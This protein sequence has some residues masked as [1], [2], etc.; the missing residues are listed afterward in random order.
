[1]SNWW[2]EGISPALLGINPLSNI[3]TMLLSNIW[4]E[5]LANDTTQVDMSTFR[6]FTDA[7]NG[8]AVQLGS[9]SP[10]NLGLTIQ[11]YYV[12]NTHITW[13]AGNWDS[14]SLGRLNIDGA[15]S[16]RWTAI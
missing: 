3:D 10:S 5:Q 1:M 13:A 16:G 12:G 8:A 9:R 14:F 11:N 2:S 4:I 15:Y 6:V 7:S